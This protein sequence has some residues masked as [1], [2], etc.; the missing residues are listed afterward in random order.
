MAFSPPTT[1]IPTG[2]P[3]TILHGII[4]TGGENAIQRPVGITVVGGEN[5]IQRHLG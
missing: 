5:A 4:M 3:K 2:I 1:E